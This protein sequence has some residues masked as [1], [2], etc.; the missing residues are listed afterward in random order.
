MNTKLNTIFEYIKR[1]HSVINR[2]LNLVQITLEPYLDV[3]SAKIYE[4]Q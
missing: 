2:S 1:K 4:E 3:H